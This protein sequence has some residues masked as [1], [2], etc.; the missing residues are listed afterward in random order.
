MAIEF[1]RRSRVRLLIQQ[2]G[3]TV[4]EIWRIHKGGKPAGHYDLSLHK[5]YWRNDQPTLSGGAAGTSR[6]LLKEA[7]QLAIDTLD[8]LKQQPSAEGEI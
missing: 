7:K 6:P 8:W 3:Q 4:G 2:N 1:V 5:V